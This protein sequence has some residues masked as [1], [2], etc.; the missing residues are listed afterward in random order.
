MPRQVSP[1]KTTISLRMRHL[2]FSE[3][4]VKN[5]ARKSTY[6]V[7]AKQFKFADKPLKKLFY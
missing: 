1:V 3:M 7:P 2:V 4:L 6:I 5:L